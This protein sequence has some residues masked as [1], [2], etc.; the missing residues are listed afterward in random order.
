MSERSRRSPLR[1]LSPAAT[2]LTIL[3]T[4]ASPAASTAA[5]T[6]SVDP[7]AGT[8]SA[9]GVVETPRLASIANFRDIAGP[10]AGYV[11]TAGLHVNRGVLY[12][13]NA[14]TPNAAD[15]ATLESLGIS[16]VYDLR[17]DGEVASA[18]DILPATSRYVHLN[19]LDG[20]PSVP[21]EALNSPE[22]ARA[23]LEGG[24]RSTAL[25]AFP[26]QRFGELLTEIAN[27][28]GPQIFHCTAGKDRTGW[29]TALLLGI[30]GVPRDV[31][32]EDYLL[33]NQYSE[34][35]TEASLEQISATQGPDVAAIYRPLF[36]VEA[37]YLEA[38]FGEVDRVYGSLD[39]YLTE[40]LGLDLLTIATLKA[41]LLL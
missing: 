17:S 27:T 35:T 37:S 6:G 19:V 32:L 9:T 23:M 34:Q 31:I 20:D 39:R 7:V 21:L 10:G 12:R 28:P 40:G 26:R 33:S 29:A 18:P 11:G 8:G 15:L 22:D 13:S 41:K 4:I 14:V 2:L 30:A 24:Y 38:A 16:A 25:D 5:P 36:E 3:V 1:R